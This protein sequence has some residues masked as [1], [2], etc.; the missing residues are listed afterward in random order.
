MPD[1]SVSLIEF[2][3]VSM[4]KLEP[5]SVVTFIGEVRLVKLVLK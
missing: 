3:E 4:V 1:V 5:A 2:D